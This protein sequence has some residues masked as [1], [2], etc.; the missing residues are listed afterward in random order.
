[1]QSRHKHMMNFYIITV[2]FIIF[3]CPSWFSWCF[4]RLHLSFA[5]DLV[6]FKV[7]L[8]VPSWIIFYQNTWFL[9]GGSF[10]IKTHYQ[11]SIHSLLCP[12]ILDNIVTPY[13][14]TNVYDSIP[15][16]ATGFKFDLLVTKV[17]QQTGYE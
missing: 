8:V 6:W 17:T 11:M 1:M 14:L 12:T 5:G 10:L 16:H 15:A 2:Y 7:L 4:H 13:S 3:P 9:V